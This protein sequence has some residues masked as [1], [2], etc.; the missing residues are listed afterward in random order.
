MVVH[1]A[2]TPRQCQLSSPGV[3]EPDQKA[4]CISCSEESQTEQG[5]Q[6]GSRVLQPAG[7]AREAITALAQ[8]MRKHWDS[9]QQGS[10]LQAD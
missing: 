3:P 2:C 9:Q 10:G 8:G 4:G 7:D 6:S 5:R 1:H